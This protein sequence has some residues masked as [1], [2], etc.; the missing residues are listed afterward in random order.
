MRLQSRKLPIETTACSYIYNADDTLQKKTDPRGASATYAY[1]GRH[2][3]TGITY[4]K[5]AGQGS[6]HEINAIPN[7]TPVG[8]GYGEADNRVWMTDGVGRVDYRYDT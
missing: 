2:L 6:E 8:F 4:A 3:V 5:P 7:V 1:N